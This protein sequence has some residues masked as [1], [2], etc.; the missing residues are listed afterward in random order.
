MVRHSALYCAGERPK[1]CR[2]LVSSSLS[3]LFG[4]RLACQ[5]SPDF[6]HSLPVPAMTC[7]DSSPYRPTRQAT[8]VES[9]LWSL[10]IHR[11]CVSPHSLHSQGRAGLRCYNITQPPNND[12]TGQVGLVFPSHSS[13]PLTIPRAP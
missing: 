6:S 11:H 10:V 3:E 8:T 7:P 2:P 1:E 4:E 9:S 13:R 5:P 12:T